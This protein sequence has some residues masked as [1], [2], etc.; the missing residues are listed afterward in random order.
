[1]GSNPIRHY[2]Y[3][4]YGPS[5]KYTWED[6]NLSVRQYVNHVVLSMMAIS[7]QSAGE[8]VTSRRCWHHI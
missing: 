2:Q 3:I 8:S 7:V 6:L 4:P 1:M 5:G